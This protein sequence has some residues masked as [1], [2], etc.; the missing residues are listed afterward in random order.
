ME[1]QV[2]TEALFLVELLS[3]QQLRIFQRSNFNGPISYT[4]NNPTAVVSGTTY[5]FQITEYDRSIYAPFAYTNFNYGNDV[6]P[7]NSANIGGYSNDLSFE[8]HTKPTLN[9][10]IKNGDSFKIIVGFSEALS[11]TPTLSLSGGVLTNVLLEQ[12]LPSNE[13]SYTWTVSGS[14]VTSTTA[15]VSGTDLSGNAYAG[16]ESITFTIDNTDPTVTLTDTDS[17]ILSPIRM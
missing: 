11:V 4:F 14:L 9:A 10:P 6:Y 1:S 16:T 2:I 7:S 12:S 13:W 15:T 17:D 3:E 8:I 5:Y